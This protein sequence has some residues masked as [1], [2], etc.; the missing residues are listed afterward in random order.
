MTKVNIIGEAENINEALELIRTL[1][2]D[3]VFLDV[4]MPYGNAFDLLD[5]VGEKYQGLVVAVTGFGL[6]VELQDLYIE[7]LVHV[8]AL[9]N[10]YYQFD[11]AKQRLLGENS[12][13]AYQL[14]DTLE[15]QVVKVDLEERK[16]DLALVKGK[17][18]KREKPSFKSKKK[19]TGGRGPRRRKAGRK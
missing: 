19:P 2:L 12:R 4:E 15:V 14:G 17:G 10:D 3:L 7:G 5:K 16:V 18:V 9:D 1:D 11:A 8:T 6:F 13:R